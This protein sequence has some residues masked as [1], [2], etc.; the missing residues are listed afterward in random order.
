M[1]MERFRV[2]VLSRHTSTESRRRNRGG[3]MRYKL[4]KHEFGSGNALADAGLPD[5]QLHLPKVDIVNRID[6]NLKE[7]RLAQVAAA[8]SMGISQPKVSKTLPGLFRSFGFERLR[9]FATAL[10]QD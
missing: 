4:P 5:D 2:E 8:R 3:T 6:N 1:R 7:R 10:G 9:L